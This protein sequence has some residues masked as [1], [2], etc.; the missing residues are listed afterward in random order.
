MQYPLV[1]RN[2]Q[3]PRRLDNT[4]Y[5]AALDLFVLDC[6]DA[7]GV[8]TGDVTARDTR[9]DRMD[10]TARHQLGL[11]NRAL[12]RLHGGFNIDYYALFHSTRWVMTDTN[13]LHLAHRRYLSDDGKYLRGPD[14]EPHHQSFIIPLCHS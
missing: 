12:N 5:V 4:L 2:G 13:D 3:C 10:P 9:V 7:V 14:V 6:D 11:L 1:R 8:E